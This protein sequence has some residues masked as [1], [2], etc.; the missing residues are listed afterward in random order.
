MGGGEELSKQTNRRLD[1]GLGMCALARCPV[2]ANMLPCALDD[3]TEREGRRKHQG[4]F[5]GLPGFGGLGF[6][7][8]N[9]AAFIQIAT[10]GVP[11]NRLIPITW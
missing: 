8:N 11:K 4:I 7:D 5:I 3:T 10:M 6:S 2:V 1:I 9:N